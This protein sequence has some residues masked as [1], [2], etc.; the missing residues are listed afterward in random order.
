M[1]AKRKRQLT[2]AKD[3]KLREII[4]ADM[5]SDEE[6]LRTVI[7]ICKLS[8]K[9][10]QQYI[11]NLRNR[12]VSHSDEFA[13]EGQLF[14]IVPAPAASPGILVLDATQ[15]K[16]LNKLILAEMNEVHLESPTSNFSG[17]EC[18]SIEVLIDEDVYKPKIYKLL[19]PVL[20]SL[21]SIL[22]KAV[23]DKVCVPLT[24]QRIFCNNYPVGSKSGMAW[25][26]DNHVPTGAIVLSLTD[27]TA[28]GTL[29]FSNPSGTEKISVP[30]RAGEAVG[31]PLS[32][33]HGVHAHI[34]TLPSNH[35]E[36]VLLRILQQ[37]PD[38]KRCFSTPPPIRY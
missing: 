23:G 14:A 31:I 30:L 15:V 38:Q 26:R 18:R 10:A 28:L 35:C 9:K 1:L 21:S 36:P 3:K 5:A 25:H 7:K 20:A 13:R 17:P 34:R 33:F 24:P 22:Q 19:L 11:W 4:G 16:A 6:T 29:Y 37:G 32:L 12:G 27:D 8:R 2:R